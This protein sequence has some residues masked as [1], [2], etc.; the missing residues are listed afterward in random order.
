M[1]PLESAIVSLLN[2]LGTD[3]YLLPLLAL[4]A[5][6]AEGG[7]QIAVHAD[8][9]RPCIAVRR[10]ARLAFANRD[11][12]RVQREGKSDRR[13]LLAE[14]GDQIVVAA[15]AA[16]LHAIIRHKDLEDQAGVI[17]LPAGIAQIN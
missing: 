1:R 9:L 10:G 4:L 17:L 11:Y 7:G 14:V 3:L 15:T 2:L 13:F 8:G 12:K 16:N 5:G 6:L